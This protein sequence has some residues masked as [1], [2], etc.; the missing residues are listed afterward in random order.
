MC[1]GGRPEGTR[2]RG[3]IADSSKEKVMLERMP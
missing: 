3:Q 1:V 2:K